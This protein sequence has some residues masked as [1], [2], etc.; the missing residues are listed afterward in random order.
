MTTRQGQEFLDCCT[1]LLHNWSVSKYDSD[2][3]T[4][5]ALARPFIGR[6]ASQYGN[7][8]TKDTTVENQNQYKIRKSTSSKIKIG[9]FR[10][11]RQS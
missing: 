7:K 4:E 10:M 5:R 2:W 9:Y 11:Y 6:E 1:W 3:R 8:V